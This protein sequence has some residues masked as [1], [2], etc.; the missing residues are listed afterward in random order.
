MA[1]PVYPDFTMLATGF[2]YSSVCTSLDDDEVTRRLNAEW[3]TGISSAWR[4]AD[5]PFRD[6]TPNPT[7]CPEAAATHRHILFNC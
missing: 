6:G 7:P 3:P 4:I 5:E 2:I 1:G